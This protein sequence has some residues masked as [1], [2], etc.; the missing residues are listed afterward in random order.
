VKSLCWVTVRSLL[1]LGSF[2]ELSAG[3]LKGDGDIACGGG[4][5]NWE[6]FYGVC[7]A[8]RALGSQNLRTCEF[9]PQACPALFQEVERGWCPHWCVYQKLLQER[10]RWGGCFP[11]A[12]ARHVQF[13]C[14]ETGRI[15]R[16]WWALLHPITVFLLALLHSLLKGFFFFFKSFLAINLTLQ[17][18]SASSFSEVCF[19]WLLRCIEDG[20]GAV[21]EG[22]NSE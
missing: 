14:C 21:D 16:A 11:A 17:N 3:R 7:A 10:A 8:G 12:P 18:K 19:L 22:E 5:A 4:R 13:A 15:R 1:C 2:R 20:R 6:R 9:V